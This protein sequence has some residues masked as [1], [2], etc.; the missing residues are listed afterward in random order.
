MSIIDT[1]IKFMVIMS[2]YDICIIDSS[3]LYIQQKSCFV[4]V[5]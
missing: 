3:S 5:E 4:F 1:I 2:I